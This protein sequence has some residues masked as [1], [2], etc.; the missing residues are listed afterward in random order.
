MK[1]IKFS[2]EEMKA[3]VGEVQEP[4]NMEA[5]KLVGRNEA[6]WVLASDLIS[7]ITVQSCRQSGLSV[8]YTELLDFDGDEVYFTTQPELVG[9]TYFDAQLAFSDSSVFGLVKGGAPVLSGQVRIGELDESVQ[10]AFKAA[11]AV[12]DQQ[13]R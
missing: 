7:R 10:E 2:R 1:P 9:K 12:G 6:H 11:Y 4:T 3:I 8:V 13:K 5:A